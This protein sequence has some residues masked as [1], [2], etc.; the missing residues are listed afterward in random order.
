MYD[1]VN[2]TTTIRSED[3]VIK[4]WDKSCRGAVA[5]HKSEADLSF[6]HS[7]AVSPC[8]SIPCRAPTLSVLRFFQFRRRHQWSFFSTNPNI[9]SGAT[10]KTVLASCEATPTRHSASRNDWHCGT[11]FQS[12]QP[13][14]SA[15][16]CERRADMA[17]SS[18]APQQL[19]QRVLRQR[20]LVI[21]N[22]VASCNAH[23]VCLISQSRPSRPDSIADGDIHVK[24][25][26]RVRVLA[27]RWQANRPVDARL[28]LY[29]VT[30]M[31]SSHSSIFAA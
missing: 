23:P 28:P 9:Q 15:A 24:E 12:K 29:S 11:K 8:D 27:G 26:Q 6:T 25:W 30:C 2:C 22:T 14:G 1:L 13:N 4:Q 7:K 20:Q 21:I 3:E 31:L 17:I 5:F 10:T 19:L 18:H 16:E